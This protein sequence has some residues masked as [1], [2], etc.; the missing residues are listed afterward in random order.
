M[1][2]PSSAGACV[3]PL[4]VTAGIFADQ[5]IDFALRG[6]GVTARC[7]DQ[8]RRHSLLVVEQRLQQV[9]RS[10]PLVMLANGDRLRRLEKPA[11]PIRQFLEVHESPFCL[12]GDIG[13]AL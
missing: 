9:R 3:A 8:P 1:V 11:C 6:L 2:S 5:R 4:P 13:V 10:D 7:L 12:G